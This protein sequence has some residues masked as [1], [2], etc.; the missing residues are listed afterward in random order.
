MGGGKNYITVNKE[1][2][3]IR[4]G[5]GAVSKKDNKKSLQNPSQNQVR[6]MWFLLQ[7]VNGHQRWHQCWIRCQSLILLIK[8]GIKERKVMVLWVRKITRKIEKPKPASSQTDEVSSSDGES[9]SRMESTSN[10]LSKYN[11]VNKERN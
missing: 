11:T 7:M 5:S 10:T 9:T 2:N 4:K 6:Q 1:R 8:K 3:K